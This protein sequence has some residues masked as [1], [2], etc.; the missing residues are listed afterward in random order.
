MEKI[1]DNPMCVGVGSV[2]CWLACGVFVRVVVCIVYILVR[3]PSNRLTSLYTLV[4]P[5]VTGPVQDPLAENT[6]TTDY[7]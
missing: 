1:A 7:I 3:D 5:T 2:Q 6:S 4:E